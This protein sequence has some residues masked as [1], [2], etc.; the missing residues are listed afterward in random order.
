MNNML[1]PD[2]VGE[3]VAWNGK[4]AGNFIKILKKRLT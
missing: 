3:G 4:K 2:R 1:K